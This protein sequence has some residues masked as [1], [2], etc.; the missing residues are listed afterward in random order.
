MNLSVCCILESEKASNETV[1]WR[2]TIVD[3]SDPDSQSDKS[4]PES[5]VSSYSS[6]TLDCII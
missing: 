1:D 2:E 6:S 3:I 4:S 5:S